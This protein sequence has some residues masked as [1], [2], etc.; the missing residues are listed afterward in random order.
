MYLEKELESVSTSALE[1]H[2]LLENSLAT[3]VNSKT[4]EN[5]VDVLRTLTE[6]QENKIEELRNEMESILIE[7]RID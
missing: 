4:T 3:Q 5:E 6:T 2:T 7:V 1:M